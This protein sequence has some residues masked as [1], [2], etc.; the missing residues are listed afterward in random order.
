MVHKRG[1]GIDPKH[2]RRPSQHRI[3]VVPRQ[4]PEGY[5]EN[6]DISGTVHVLVG[7]YE[8]FA[9]SAILE[10]VLI[11]I[12]F[13]IEEADWIVQLMSVPIGRQRD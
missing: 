2:S 9:E 7:I 6:P 10:I 8:S 4:L 12:V 3:I 1:N 13:G 11:E 5:P